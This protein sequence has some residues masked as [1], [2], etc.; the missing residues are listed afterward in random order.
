[1]AVRHGG[2]RSA[3]SGATCARAAERRTTGAGDSHHQADVH[4]GAEGAGV[5]AF[6]DIPEDNEEAFPCPSCCKGTVSKSKED[7]TWQCNDCEWIA[8][9]ENG[10]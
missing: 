1:M 3:V 5:V 10:E 2:Q 9:D 7:G 8:E 6:D 4:G